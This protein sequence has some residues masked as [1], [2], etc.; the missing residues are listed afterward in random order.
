[1][2]TELDSKNVSL[3]GQAL[4]LMHK[5]VAPE[6]KHTSWNYFG[7]YTNYLKQR[8]LDSTLF[9]YKDHRFGCLSRAAAVLVNNFE[10]LAGFLSDNPHICLFS[11]RTNE[12]APPKGGLLCLCCPRGAPH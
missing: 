9:S 3:A 4:D 8:E 12:Y 1:M 6:H 7:L 2:S 10:H 5:L 11:Q